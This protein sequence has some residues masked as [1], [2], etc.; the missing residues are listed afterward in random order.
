[1]ID[2]SSSPTHPQACSSCPRQGTTTSLCQARGVR[3]PHSDAFKPD[4]LTCRLARRAGVGV[5]G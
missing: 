4:T 2:R 1:M 5:G 3:G